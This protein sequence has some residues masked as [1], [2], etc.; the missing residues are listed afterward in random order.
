MAPTIAEKTIAKYKNHQRF[1]KIQRIEVATWS[2]L[3]SLVDKKVIEPTTVCSVSNGST[4]TVS[5]NANTYF[6][7]KYL[8]N[9]YKK[10]KAVC[11][12]KMGHF[13]P[14]FFLY[15]RLFNTVAS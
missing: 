13:R 8:C 14:C 4:T 5:L 10:L 6:A 12:I 1:V 9:L 3:D 7:L 11:F 15:F 2:L